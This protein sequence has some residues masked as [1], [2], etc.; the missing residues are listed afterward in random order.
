M[1]DLNLV[2]LAPSMDLGRL[3]RLAQTLTSAHFSIVALMESDKVIAIARQGDGPPEAGRES[4]MSAW[5]VGADEPVFWVEDCATDRRFCNLQFVATPPYLRF[6]CGAPIIVGGHKVGVLAVADTDVRAFDQ[7]LADRLVDIAAIISSEFELKVAKRKLAAEES[8]VRSEKTLLDVLIEDAPLA[9]AMFDREMRY[10]RTSRR[11]RSD[12]GEEGAQLIGRSHYEVQP[13]VHDAWKACHQRCL[14]GATER[15]EGEHYVDEFGRDRWVRWEVTP[16]YEASG[17][18]GGV[19]IMTEDLTEQMLS[20]RELERSE[21]RL[22]LATEI[23]DLTVWDYSFEERS[24]QYATG[25]MPSAFAGDLSYER[26][27]REWL[28]RVHEDDRERVAA[29][30]A[31]SM[32]TGA[33]FN[34]EYRQ[35]DGLHRAVWHQNVADI[36]RNGDGEPERI[37][38]VVRDV[39]ERKLGELAVEQARNEAENANRAKSE[40]LANMSHEIRT[41]LNGVLGVA[42]ALARSDLTPEQRQMVQI[43]EHS[44]SVLQALL[45]DVLDLARI[46]SGKLEIRPEGFDLAGALREIGHLFQSGAAAKGLELEVEIDPALEGGFVADPVRIRQVISNLLSNAVKF[47]A[48]GRV[49]LSARMT[50][51]AEDMAVMRIA[52]S[53]TG[54][55]FDEATRLRLFERFEQADGSIT[56]QF[57]GTGLGLSICRSLATMMGGRLWAESTPGEG[58]TFTLELELKRDAAVSTA[59]PDAAPVVAA[60]PSGNAQAVAADSAPVRVLLA[61]DHPT[62]RRVVELILDGAGVDLT[63]VE[64]GALA[65][66]MF[67]LAEFDLILM[68]MQ[69]PVMDGLNATRSI[70][71]T[72]RAEGRRPTP[73]FALTANAMPEHVE[74]TRAAGADGH[75][76]KPLAAEALLEIIEK[77]RAVALDRSSDDSATAA[78]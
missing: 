17:D 18:I 21:T 77:V 61:E 57:G 16:W 67:G 14:A 27:I 7:E 68:D 33:L 24:L 23:S 4:A 76:T 53:D 46:E 26:L 28:A 72:E 22:R 11:W 19:V 43:I 62:N 51:Q 32:Q 3:T 78:A 50:A 6:Y 49:S 37:V 41:P 47:T 56:R 54:I 55:G 75:L 69:M 35:Y 64:N 71:A 58:S 66:E 39:T 15:H 29:L 13:R 63:A 1:R 44:G 5:V 40:F 70:R 36:I 48:R 38:G 2:E 42:S 59:G 65:V 10:I 30:W 31:Q 12:R 34:C 20:R 25:R 8:R 9:L 74:Q 73:I 52:V 45:S 60:T